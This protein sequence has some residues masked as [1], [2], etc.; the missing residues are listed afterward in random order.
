M[1]CG[2]WVEAKRNTM[3]PSI[4]VYFQLILSNRHAVFFA[5]WGI[6]FQLCGFQNERIQIGLV[7]VSAEPEG[8]KVIMFSNVP[9]GQQITN[10]ETK[11]RL[12]FSCGFWGTAE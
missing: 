5:F 3:L 2:L 7:H 1:S 8:Q 6:F 11:G 4:L 9:T 12:S 10:H